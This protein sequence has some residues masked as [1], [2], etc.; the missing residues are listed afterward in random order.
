MK[1]WFFHEFARLLEP[2]GQV[3]ALDRATTEHTDFRATRVPVGL[4]DVVQLP[5]LQ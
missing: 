1:L 4:C 2:F 3:L 5:P